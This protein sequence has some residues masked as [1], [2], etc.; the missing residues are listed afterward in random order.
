MTMAERISRWTRCGL[1]VAAALALSSTALAGAAPT[2]VFLTKSDEC[3]CVLNVSVAG[4][5]EVVNFIADNPYG[6]QYE[7]IDLAEDPA[8]GRA[9]RV[10]AVPVVVLQDEEGRTVARFDSFFTEADFY[11]AWGAY[12]KKRGGQQ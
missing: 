3:E 8:A 11:K 4:E 12:E 1:A 7:R 9:Y 5:Q 10:F 2:L 6:F